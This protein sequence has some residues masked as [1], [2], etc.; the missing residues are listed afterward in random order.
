MQSKLNLSPLDIGI[1]LE[2]V[3]KLWLGYEA[4]GFFMVVAL[5]V[6]VLA[7]SSKTKSFYSFCALFPSQW[8]HAPH[9]V[10]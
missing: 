5:T 4:F 1:G 6:A 7:L 9:S 3:C 10:V 8:S 2:T